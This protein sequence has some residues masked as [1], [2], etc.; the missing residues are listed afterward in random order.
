MRE[1]RFRAVCRAAVSLL[2]SGRAVFSPIAHSH[3][4]V[5]YGLPT[6]WEF[7]QRTNIEHLQRFDEVVVL[8]LNGWK[9]SI[10]V[11]TEVRIAG[12]LGK[13][14]SYLAPD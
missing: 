3:P 4:L 8:T 1:E 6:N 10:G 14:V 5:E 9:E 7:W 11:Q 2:K 13:P 12:D